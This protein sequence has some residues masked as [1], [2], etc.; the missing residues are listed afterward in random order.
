MTDEEQTMV[1]DTES[2][3]MTEEEKAQYYAQLRAEK[4]RQKKGELAYRSVKYSFG[5]PIVK[6]EN[7]VFGWHYEGKDVKQY[8]AGYEVNAFGT[9]LRRKIKII[10][11]AYFS[12]PKVWSS[13]FLT[14]LTETVSRIVSWFRR[15]ALTFFWLPILIWM[16][17]QFCGTSSATIDSFKTTV[18]AIYAGLII[19]SFVLIGL[20]FLWQKVFKLREKCD[21]E[22]E[23]NGFIAWSETDEGEHF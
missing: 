17:M 13:N 9:G 2:P 3:V 23:K 4:N 21:Q 10:K 14:T 18:F 12:R 5:C 20:G 1:A 15:V 19:A 6:L 16:G 22:L 7:R 8:N 11:T